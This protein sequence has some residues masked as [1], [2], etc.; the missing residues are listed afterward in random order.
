MEKEREQPRQD[1]IGSC[2]GGGAEIHV[3][4]LIEFTFNTLIWWVLAFILGKKL[5]VRRTTKLH[6]KNDSITILQN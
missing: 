3:F 5:A 6:Y 4:H 2:C 1:L